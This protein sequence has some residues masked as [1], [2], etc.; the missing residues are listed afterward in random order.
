MKP[1]FQH[2]KKRQ[3]VKS[4][5]RAV[6]IHQAPNYKSPF[7]D[8]QYYH[9]GLPNNYRKV[10][11]GQQGDGEPISGEEAERYPKMVFED[12]IAKI[13]EALKGKGLIK[14]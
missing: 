9:Y 11:L 13:E 3:S 8:T 1:S 6:V 7:F 10:K 5:S 14:G 4:N 2:A 12:Q